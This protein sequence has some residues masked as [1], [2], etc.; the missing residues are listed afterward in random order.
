M[1]LWVPIS[2]NE[3]NR[4]T[5]LRSYSSLTYPSLS[6]STRNLM[7]VSRRQGR[8]YK[9]HLWAQ[10]SS[11]P[12]SSPYRRS[13]FPSQISSLTNHEHADVHLFTFSY[14]P[15][16][17]ALFFRGRSREAQVA[18]RGD[19][20]QG[21][22][23]FSLFPFLWC[24]KLSYLRPSQFIAGIFLSFGGLLSEVVGG[25]SAGLTASNPGLVKLLSGFVFPVGLVMFVF[26]YLIFLDVV[27]HLKPQDCFEW[28]RTPH[29]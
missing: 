27:F 10:R 19:I 6:I 3:I 12:S 14:S 5:D 11:F 25:G 8:V 20:L 15:R 18:T 2:Q 1:T 7:V 9:E 16:S 29:K 23:P 13:S 24:S 26:F 4:Q 28:S 17:R 22:K 21:C